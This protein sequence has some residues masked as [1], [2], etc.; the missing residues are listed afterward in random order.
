MADKVKITLAALALILG[1]VGFYYYGQQ[2]LVARVGMVLAGIALAVALGWSSA[3][4][5]ALQS[6]GRESLEETKKVAWPTRK[7]SLQTTAIVFAFILVMAL[8]LWVVDKGLE[9]TMYDLILG[10]KR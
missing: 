10:W 8:F 7:E 3:Q 2:P 9:W 4:G 6:F 5:R 1:L